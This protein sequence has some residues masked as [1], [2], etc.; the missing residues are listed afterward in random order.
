[1]YVGGDRRG[2]IVGRRV[3]PQHQ[4]RLMARCSQRCNTNDATCTKG[5]KGSDNEGNDNVLTSSHV[6]RGLVGWR[7]MGCGDRREWG[8]VGG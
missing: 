3:E 6:D 7:V 2:A 8:G 5:D 4:A 1:M